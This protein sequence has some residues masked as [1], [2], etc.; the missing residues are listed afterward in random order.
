MVVLKHCCKKNSTKKKKKCSCGEHHASLGLTYTINCPLYTHPVEEFQ[1][2]DLWLGPLEN[3]CDLTSRVAILWKKK[4]DN[5]PERTIYQTMTG[6]MGA[7][8]SHGSI[9]GQLNP[10]QPATVY[11]QRVYRI[12]DARTRQED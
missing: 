1:H 12:A 6:L 10:S 2:E 7:F 11:R 4:E 8:N 5:D 3:H 9:Q